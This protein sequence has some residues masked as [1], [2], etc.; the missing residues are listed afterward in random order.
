MD[1][2]VIRLLPIQQCDSLPILAFLYLLKLFHDFP[3]LLFDDK[4]LQP[5]SVS[6]KGKYFHELK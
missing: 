4:W 6:K 3:T 5:Q 2:D 1:I